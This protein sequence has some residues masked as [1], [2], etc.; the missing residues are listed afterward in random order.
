M[1]DAP[2]GPEDIESLLVA[3]A[4][5]LGAS[6]LVHEFVMVG[7][8]LPGDPPDPHLDSHVDHIARASHA[9]AERDAARGL[10]P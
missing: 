4:Q 9:R 3:L 1:R 8:S 10:D 7:G 6:G 2:L 5:E